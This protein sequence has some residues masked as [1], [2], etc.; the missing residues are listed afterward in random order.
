MEEKAAAALQPSA[1]AFSS[2]GDGQNVLLRMLPVAVMVTD[3]ATGRVVELNDSCLNLL[4]M[5]RSRLLGRTLAEAGLEMIV[6]YGR[7]GR[8][9]GASEAVVVDSSGARV[10]CRCYS[11]V[12]VVAGTRVAVTVLLDDQ[13]VAATGARKAAEPRQVAEP[14]RKGRPSALLVSLPGSGDSA[15]EM[16]QLLGFDLVQGQSARDVLD[17][18]PPGSK[19]AMAVI[20]SPAGASECAQSV[21]VLRK[22]HPDLPLILLVEPGMGG[23]AADQGI[24]LLDKPIGIN[25]LAD[26]ASRA[27]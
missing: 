18:A 2:D 14:R 22:A 8:A 12:G 11:S 27:R 16:L 7:K 24:T 13:F 23:P 6:E 25:D 4:G 1:V 17:S 3:A 9:L 15:G 26:A 19:P 21:D 20:D 10:T 5:Q